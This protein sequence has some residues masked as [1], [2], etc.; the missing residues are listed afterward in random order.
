MAYHG[1]PWYTIGI[2]IGRMPSNTNISR[3]REELW[4]QR[5]RSSRDT[6]RGPVTKSILSRLGRSQKATAEDN[7]TTYLLL[8][9]IQRCDQSCG[10]GRWDKHRVQAQGGKQ[11]SRLPWTGLPGHQLLSL[12]CR[13][14]AS[15]DRGPQAQAQS[16]CPK[17]Q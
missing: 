9:H 1:I 13:G 6:D 4:A 8:H 3:W 10:T 15:P 14:R 11:L 2:G 16:T 5:Q 12:V 17:R 7:E